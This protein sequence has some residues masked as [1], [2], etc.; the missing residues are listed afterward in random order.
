MKLSLSACVLRWLAMEATLLSLAP[1]NLLLSAA[2]AMKMANMLMGQPLETFLSDLVSFGEMSNAQKQSILKMTDGNAGEDSGG[3]RINAFAT[4]ES[5]EGLRSYLRAEV[6][7]GDLGVDTVRA[8]GSTLSLGALYP[9]DAEA[10]AT[11]VAMLLDGPAQ[12]VYDTAGE[13]NMV[14]LGTSRTLVSANANNYHHN[15][16]WGYATGELFLQC[17]FLGLDGNFSGRTLMS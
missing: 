4:E 1:A 12:A 9:D 8:I 16:I 5:K 14:R 11:A 17:S 6:S 15:G 10:A 3:H 13:G 7:A 2:S